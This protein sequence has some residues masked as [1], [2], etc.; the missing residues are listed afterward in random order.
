MTLPEPQA[1]LST[2]RT[3]RTALGICRLENT[4]LWF[5]WRRLVAS[6]GLGAWTSYRLLAESQALPSAPL[7][8]AASGLLVCTC[9]W[10]EVVSSKNSYSPT[11]PRGIPGLPPEHNLKGIS[12]AVANMTGFLARALETHPDASFEEVLRIIVRISVVQRASTPVG[13]AK[14]C[15]ASRPSDANTSGRPEHPAPQRPRHAPPDGH[16]DKSGPGQATRPAPRASR[17]RTSGGSR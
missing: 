15:S 17:L 8:Y 2:K 7:S 9:V 4:I 3:V 12:F 11:L 1:T 16:G 13:D 10:S 5:D 14:S 6:F